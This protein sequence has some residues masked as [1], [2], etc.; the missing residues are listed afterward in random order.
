MGSS[1]VS[2]SLRGTEIAEDGGR[3]HLLL[4]KRFGEWPRRDRGVTLPKSPEGTEDLA[5]AVGTKGCRWQSEGHPHERPSLNPSGPPSA[6]HPR[7]HRHRSPVAV[8]PA[9]PVF[10]PP[11]SPTPLS[12][13]P[14]RHPVASCSKRGQDAAHPEP[15]RGLS[16]LLHPPPPWVSDQGSPGWRSPCVTCNSGHTWG[17]GCLCPWR[18]PGVGLLLQSH[19]VCPHGS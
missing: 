15:F 7:R 5:I 3:K 11:E 4:R 6:W 2:V 16:P 1:G 17:R 18:P 13:V 9:G 12:G 19:P 14:G 10:S 8:P